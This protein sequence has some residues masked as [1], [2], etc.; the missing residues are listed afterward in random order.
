MI[1]HCHYIVK[2]EKYYLQG[3]IFLGLE[4]SLNSKRME[5]ILQIT[6]TLDI[7]PSMR[8]DADNKYHAITEYLQSHGV[9]CNI[10]PQGSFALGVV[11]RP[12]DKDG[13]DL[14]TICELYIDKQ[15]TSAKEVKESVGNVL[16][17]SI[18]YGDVKE[19][20]TCWTKEY[21]EGFSIDIVPAVNEEDTKKETLAIKS[22]SNRDLTE[23]AI[24]ITKGTSSY[25]RWSTSNPKGYREWF[26]RINQPFLEYNRDARRRMIFE[27][28]RAV[29]DSVEEIP[30]TDERS[31]L[32]VAIQIL[33]RHR[34][35]Y[36]S[37]I[38]KGECNRPIS[39]IIVTI[40][41]SIAKNLSSHLGV[42]E[43]LGKIAS[44][45]KIYSQLA[46]MDQIRFSQKY[47]ALDLI[48]RDSGQWKLLNPANPEDNLLDSWNEKGSQ[49]AYWFFQ[50]VT[51]VISDFEVFETG[52]DNQY[53]AT[54]KTAF[55][56]SLV[57][58]SSAFDHYNSMESS[59]NS[60]PISS[61]VKPWKCYEIH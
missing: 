45:L 21:A 7:S 10:Y 51:K 61:P 52:S 18:R 55:G 33:K 32:Q 49:R 46:E 11:V 14:D 29:F 13:F 28:N 1:P 53:L 48:R 25:Y 17:E 20:D 47:A 15:D 38:P 39:A 35:I 4:I 5:E 31:A 40:A 6:K 27:Q 22:L 12:L 59:S 2:R 9:E 36:F 43:L 37:R 26:E 41:A 8:Q 30:E 3:C 60:V 34:S 42:F 24:A 56:R 57:E 50:W 54:V 58:N 44:E 23:K 16:K 19:Y